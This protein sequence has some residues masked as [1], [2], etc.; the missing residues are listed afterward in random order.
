MF[1]DRQDAGIQLAK[2]MM[3][4]KNQ[5]GLIVLGLARGGVAVAYEIAKKL[6]VPLNVVVPRKVG[7]PEEPEL[8]I[9]AIM[10]DGKGIFDE[11]IIQCLQVSQKYIQS[12]I[13]KQKAIAQERLELYRQY[14]PLP[15]LKGSTVILADD[16]IAT[17]STMLVVIDA[18]RR[19][20]AK[21]IIVA[22]PVAASDSLIKI[23]EKADVIV[24]LHNQYDF[25][26]VGSFYQDFRQVEDNEVVELLKKANQAS[27]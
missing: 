7:A 23:K 24:C 8:A 27:N 6:E 20:N 12:E 4:Y 10:E 22:V 19:N 16:G 2:Q 11:Y 25:G 1:R 17:G 21:E 15:H 18:M 5:K 13:K 3:H 26:S 9:G 14:A